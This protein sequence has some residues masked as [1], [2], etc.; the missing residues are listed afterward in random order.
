MV[1]KFVGKLIKYTLIT[2]ALAFTHHSCY[3][4]GIDKGK[5]TGN[6]YNIHQESETLYITNPINHEEY[7]LDFKKEQLQ[8]K[9]NH[10]EE[11]VKDMR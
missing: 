7:I 10:L 3:Q 11:L 5:E 2:G 4:Q 1:F 6:P 8:N 9:K